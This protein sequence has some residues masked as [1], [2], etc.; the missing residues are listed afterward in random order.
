M[1]QGFQV[2]ACFCVFVVTVLYGSWK[3]VT[4][5]KQDKKTKHMPFTSCVEN[6]YQ[7]TIETAKQSLRIDVLLVCCSYVQIDTC[8]NLPQGHKKAHLP[9]ERFVLLVAGLLA[10]FTL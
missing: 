6:D 1:F 4:K 10:P 3:T 2:V 8:S 7:R 5:Q 9:K